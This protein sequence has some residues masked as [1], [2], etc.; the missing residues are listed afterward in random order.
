MRGLNTCMYLDTSCVLILYSSTGNMWEILARRA[1]GV[2]FMLNE[3][4]VKIID[5]II[6]IIEPCIL[7]KRTCA[8]VSSVKNMYTEGLLPK[9]IP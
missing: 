7:K 8:D 1:F 2:V 6:S 3:K 4:L 9:H 5:T